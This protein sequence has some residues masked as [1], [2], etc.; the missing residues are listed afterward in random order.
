MFLPISGCLSLKKIAE[1]QRQLSLCFIIKHKFMQR[2]TLGIKKNDPLNLSFQPCC[3]SVALLGQCANSDIRL[4]SGADQYEGRVEICFN[5]TWGT[6][7]DYLWSIGDANVACR[8][9]G[10][11][12]TGESGY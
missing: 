7:C 12:T 1:K 6:I 2:K 8:Q 3:D 4:A 11:G 9:L 10:F 5:N